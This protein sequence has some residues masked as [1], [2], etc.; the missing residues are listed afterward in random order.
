[1]GLGVEVW[2]G[3][4]LVGGFRD[5]ADGVEDV[6]RERRVVLEERRDLGYFHGGAARLAGVD[7]E[8]G[9]LGEAVEGENPGFLSAFLLLVEDSFSAG[10]HGVVD[11][12]G[13]AVD[14]HF[15]DEGPSVYPLDLEL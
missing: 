2:G 4:E 15:A 11:A 13:V 1:M 12:R 14:A 10:G 6:F 3:D 8:E 7:E 5:L 9:E